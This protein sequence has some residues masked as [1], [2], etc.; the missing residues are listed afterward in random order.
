MMKKN[1]ASEEKETGYRNA[2]PQAYNLSQTKGETYQSPIT[3]HPLSFNQTHPPIMHRLS[4]IL[5][6]LQSLQ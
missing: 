6:L 5:V 1:G 4:G 3:L 2:A